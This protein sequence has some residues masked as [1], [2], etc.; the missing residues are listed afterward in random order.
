[1]V[2]SRVLGGSRA[3]GQKFFEVPNSQ[4]LDALCRLFI[5]FLMHFEL[6]I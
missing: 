3:L 6:M 4:E 2:L 1:M 5:L